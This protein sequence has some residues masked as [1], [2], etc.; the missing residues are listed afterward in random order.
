MVRRADDL[1]YVMSMQTIGGVPVWVRP[2][3]V[4]HIKDGDAPGVRVVFMNGMA[5]NV[6]EDC[7]GLIQRWNEALRR[8]RAA[9]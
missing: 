8:E 1:R 9:S 4:T 3:S 7:E 6:D 2:T 5:I